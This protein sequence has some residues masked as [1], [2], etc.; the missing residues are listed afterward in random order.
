MSGIGHWWSRSKY[1]SKSQVPTL[2]QACEL[3]HNNQILIKKFGEEV[4]FGMEGNLGS[5]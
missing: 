2:P 3:R 1:V 4:G 5:L